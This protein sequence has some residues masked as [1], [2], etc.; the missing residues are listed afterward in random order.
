MNCLR[1]LDNRASAEPPAQDL[2]VGR[3]QGQVR[4]CAQV[5]EHLLALVEARNVHGLIS[6]LVFI[7]PEYSPSEELVSLAEVD[8]LDLALSS[9]GQETT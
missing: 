4:R 5:L 2:D 7:V 6:K 3:T 1:S 8:Q 9:V